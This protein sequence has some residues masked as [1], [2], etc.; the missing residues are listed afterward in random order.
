MTLQGR[1]R[2][3]KDS[4]AHHFTVKPEF[5][6]GLI[7]AMLTREHA[8]L[9]GPPGTA[10]SATVRALTSHFADADYFESLLHKD[11]PDSAV[12]GPYDLPLLTSE[13][14]YV[15]RTEGYLPTAHVAFLDEAFKASA[16]LQNALLAALN[17]R[18]LHEVRDGRSAQPIPLHSAFAASNEG[19]Q[20]LGEESRAFWDR[21][22]FRFHVAPVNS[23]SDFQRMLGTPATYT[24]AAN[25]LLSMADLDRA[26]AEVDRVLVPDSTLAAL[27]QLRSLLMKSEF[28]RHVSPRRWRKAVHVLQA[29]AWRS[30]FESTDQLD[31]T[32]YMCLTPLL[33]DDP[34]HVSAVV[35]VIRDFIDLEFQDLAGPTVELRQMAEWV[36]GQ[37]DANPSTL[38][39]ED[40]AR[41]LDI[42]RR[43]TRLL[44]YV[45][46]IRGKEKRPG[47]RSVR[48]DALLQEIA[49]ARA[50][51][52]KLVAL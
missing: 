34:K 2:E 17:E 35:S 46:E 32:A 37:I 18:V 14:K 26:C 8:I 30:G 23:A 25:A 38:S 39:G 19:W 3:I 43:L 21:M 45:Q 50:D 31:R 51:V 20:A 42:S 40:Q 16:T 28:G 11:L 10:K 47:S 13:G 48:I 33:W 6:D 29:Q 27:F 1:F 36:A 9:L 12:L 41:A 15:R 49:T 22:L 4:L 5:L 24:P 7:L 52:R 44:E